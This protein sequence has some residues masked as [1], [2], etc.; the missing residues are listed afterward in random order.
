MDLPSSDWLF[1]VGIEAGCVATVILPAK[2]EE[3]LLPATIDALARQ[4]DARGRPLDARSFEVLVLLN[5]CS[6]ASAAVLQAARRRH[7]TM[8]LHFAECT[9]S[10]EVAHVG[11]ARRMLMNAAWD[12][13]ARRCAQTSATRVP[14]VLLSTD[15]D[16]VVAPD[17]IS[18]CSAVFEAGADVVGG[19]IE[20]SASDCEVLGRTQPELML[21]YHRDRRYQQLLARLESLLDPDPYDPWPR[22]LEHFGASLGCTA[23]I[24]ARA[25]GLPAVSPL[26]DVAF[27]RALRRV[28]AR[29]R[30]APEVR[31]H[32]SGRLMGRADVGLSWQLRRW[33]EG[34]ARGAGQL[35]PACEW[36]VHRLRT[37]R[38]LRHVH[39]GADAAESEQ[40]DTVLQVAEV[41]RLLDA[42]LS[43]G[44]FLEE[45]EVDRVAEQTYAGYADS[46]EEPITAVLHD[47][48]QWLGRFAP[49]GRGETGRHARSEQLATVAG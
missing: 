41:R 22:H 26:E 2:D 16:T 20:L 40:V 44:E 8:R 6:D 24:Y 5:N 49:R 36:T 19:V 46:R 4:V 47:L 45:V 42:P 31:V 17:W 10:A 7:P 32:T 35:A 23:E 38:A 3:T 30:H 25:G 12:R 15:A 9:L 13:Q 18:R 1:P 21:A 29:I 11:T 48:E 43:L 33:S 34:A 27:I 28:G 37:Q 39:A 14:G